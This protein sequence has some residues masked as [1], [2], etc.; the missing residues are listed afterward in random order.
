MDAKSKLQQKVLALRRGYTAKDIKYVCSRE[1]NDKWWAT[2]QISYI[3]FSVSRLFNSKR[4]AETAA[5]QKGLDCWSKVLETLCGNY[6][7]RL[8]HNT[9][10]SYSQQRKNTPRNTFYEEEEEEEER[11]NSEE[12]GERWNFGKGAESGASGL[13]QEDYIELGKLTEKIFHIIQKKY[14]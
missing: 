12:G 2:V 13:S 9:K 11:W 1:K 4:Q 7:H 5:A 3:N 14:S 8:H 6:S 10:H